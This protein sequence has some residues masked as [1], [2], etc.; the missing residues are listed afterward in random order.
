VRAARALA[1]LAP[2]FALL[3]AFARADDAPLRS[4]AE[5]D[6]LRSEIA[7]TR[8]RVVAHEQ[9]ERDILQLLERIDRGLD[10]LREGVRRS[11]RRAAQAQEDFAAVEERLAEVKQSLA[12]T[13]RAM[14]KRAVALYKTGDIGPLRV[15]FASVDL[16]QVLSK[17]WTLERLLRYDASLVDR[18]SREHARLVA[19]EEEAARTLAARDEA[20]ARLAL[21]SAAL[22]QERSL[23]RSLLARVRDDR[24]H[25]RS[26]LVELERAARA[27][28]ETLSRLGD[29]EVPRAELDGSQFAALRGRLDHPVEGRVRSR[30]G[31]VVDDEYQT[32]TFNNGMEIAAV[33]GESVRAVA[34]GQVRF[35]GWFRGYGKIVIV[36]H[37][38]GYF[39][40]SGHLA[41]IFVGVGDVVDAGDTL[42]SVG[43]T[44]SL[45]GSGLYFEVRSGS[46]PLDP[47][48]WLATG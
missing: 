35:A 48:H 28:E 10:A 37:G 46:E 9:E 27:L 24:S 16:Q 8:E 22:E 39:T 20:R 45:R 7:R 5:I 32:E 38:G 47:A 42:G 4:D 19:I 15:L 29:A 12:A 1:L 41:D 17:M 13:R 43:D 36:D 21:R 33:A 18:F 6:A 23:R 31:R 25:E 3:A 26:L 2:V 11:E 40:V 34:R 44:G 14:S 30:F